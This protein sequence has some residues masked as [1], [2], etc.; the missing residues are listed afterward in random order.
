MIARLRR[1]H[2]AATF[3]LP[4]VWNLQK[5]NEV[6]KTKHDW[7]IFEHER[8]ILGKI[9]FTYLVRKSFGLQLP[10]SQLAS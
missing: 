3:F 5:A 7:S 9:D 10:L 4:R 2:S 8:S 6:L 1:S